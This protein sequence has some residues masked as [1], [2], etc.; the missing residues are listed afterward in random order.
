MSD[1][2]IAVICED[3]YHQGL[4]DLAGALAARRPSRAEGRRVVYLSALG[5]GRLLPV[6]HQVLRDG[7]PGLAGERPRAVAVVVDA[8]RAFEL[9]RSR[10]REYERRPRTG[11]ELD[12]WRAS[13][14]GAIEHLLREQTYDEDAR[15]RLF[16]FTLCW[17]LESV[18]LSVPARFA[19][20]AG[21][22]Q[23]QEGK[24]DALLTACVP[25]DPRAVAPGEFAASFQR[26]GECFKNLYRVATDRRPGKERVSDMVGDIARS[27]EGDWDD[28]M[29]RV[30]GLEALVT[31]LGEPRGGAVP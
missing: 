30:P 22:T 15:A 31:W 9:H 12:V 27:L 11:A 10:F 21:A 4:A 7:V 6:A 28:V 3:A 18:A 1:D 2:L 24:V 5:M 8:D 13:L 29:A 26:P 17:S 25:A 14:G 16:A 20:L 23:E 19:K